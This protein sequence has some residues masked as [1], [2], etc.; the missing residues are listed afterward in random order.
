MQTPTAQ[1][2][3]AK[4]GMILQVKDVRT[5]GEELNGQ[6][7]PAIARC[8]GGMC[9]WCV[10]QTSRSSPLTPSKNLGKSHP[11]KQAVNFSLFFRLNPFIPIPTTALQRSFAGGA[12]SR[13]NS[14]PPSLMITI[15][16]SPPP[17]PACSPRRHPMNAAPRNPELRRGIG[18]SKADVIGSNLE[19]KNSGFSH[20]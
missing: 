20:C 19:S 16:P 8:G 18:L 7:V 12:H 1:A 6:L 9:N 14:L 5:R 2:L 13:A 10:H 17:P 4:A 3:P 11:V 15:T